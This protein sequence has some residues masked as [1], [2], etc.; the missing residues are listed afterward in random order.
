MCISLILVLLQEVPSGTSSSIEA[1]VSCKDDA[2][3]AD[4]E[5]EEAPAMETDAGHNA[6]SASVDSAVPS[7]EDS[8]PQ[9]IVSVSR[10]CVVESLISTLEITFSELR[11]YCDILGDAPTSMYKA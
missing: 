2:V 9:D 8:P 10:H 3:D 7:A 4:V 11:E 1:A 5:R 6:S